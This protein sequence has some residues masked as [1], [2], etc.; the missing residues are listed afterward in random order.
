MTWN[1]TTLIATPIV[2]ACIG[3]IAF[4]AR[5]VYYEWIRDKAKKG[6]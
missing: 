4:V 5:E 1:T 6:C 2:L 3:Y